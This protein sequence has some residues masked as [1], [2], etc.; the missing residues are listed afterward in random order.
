MSIFR[1]HHVWHFQP[2]QRQ[3]AADINW[4]R[5]SQPDIGKFKYC[6]LRPRQPRRRLRWTLR[7][8]CPTY[9]NKEKLDWRKSI[10]DLMKLL[11]LD[12]SLSARQ[13][14]AKEL[15]YTGD[16]ANSAAIEYLAAQAGNDQA[17]R[18]RREG[19]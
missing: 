8:F 15:H 10:V 11:N 19:S 13:D 1:K 9:Q 16:V 4:Q 14:L 5:R 2:W 18:E 12:S 6:R 7:P 3:S 17:R